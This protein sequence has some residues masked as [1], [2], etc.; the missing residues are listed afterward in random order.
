M[1]IVKPPFLSDKILNKSFT[2]N[3]SNNENKIFLTFDDGPTE[4]ITNKI[5]NILEEFKI[6]ATFFCIGRNVD[7]FK[8]IYQNIIDNGHTTGVHSYS[9]L[10]G[11]KVKFDEYINDIELSKSLINSKL[12]RPPYGKIKPKQL[13][14]LKDHFKII[15][16]DVLSGDYNQNL[17]KESVL[18]NVIENTKS[19]SII[20]FHDS[21]KAEKNM[22]YALPRSI[23]YLLEK[24]FIF[25][26][27]K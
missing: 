5:L 10:N 18:S 7:R 23:E 22:L 19:G 1:Q 26:V 16:W 11:W 13:K 15:M 3:I 6:K 24:G 17:S 25:D 4:S 21:E 8:N 9:H 2:W 20:V 12:Y 14:N 27:I